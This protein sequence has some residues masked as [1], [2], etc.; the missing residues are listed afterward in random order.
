MTSTTLSQT[1]LNFARFSIVSIDINKLPLKDILTIFI[2]PTDLDQAIQN[3]DPLLKGK[4]KLNPDQRNT[5]CNTS[6]NPPDYS[7]F[8]I[9]LLYRLIRNLCPSLEPTNKWGNKPA[10]NDLDVGDDIERIRYLRNSIVA[11]SAS[12]EISDDKFKD[13]WS[14]VKCIIQR[15]QQYTTSKGCTNDYNKMLID[16]ERK[17]FTFDEYTIQKARSRAICVF[18]ESEIFCGKTACFEAEIT[19]EDDVFL[20]VSWDRVDGMHRKQLDVRDEKYR[21]SDNRQLR[22]HNVCKDDEAGYQAVLSR[23]YDVK[24]LSNTVY[25]RPK[26]DLP[27]LE[28]LNATSKEGTIYIHYVFKVSE[29]SPI[30]DIRWTKNNSELQVPGDKYR[31]GEKA[32]SCFTIL[33]AGEDDMGLYTC[34]VWNAVGSVSKNIKL[35]IPSADIVSTSNSKVVCGSDTTFDCTVSGY[36]SPD[37]VKWQHSPDGNLFI[38]L[39][40][41]TDKYLQSRSSHSLLVRKATLKQ[42]GYYQVVVSNSIGKCTSNKLF[43]QLTGSK[44]NVS[45]VTCSLHGNSVKLKCDVFLYDESPPLNYVYWTK[46]VKH[47]VIAAND[48]KYSGADINDPSLTIYNVNNDDAGEYQLIAVNPVGETWST[49]I[50]LGVPEVL[51]KECVKK[52]DGSLWFTMTIKSVPV[53]HSVKWNIKENNTDTFE[54]I[55]VSAAEYIGTSTTFP[56]PVLVIKHLEKLDNCI[57]EIEVKNR[58]G[59]VKRLI[60]GNIFQEELKREKKT[61]GTFYAEGGSSI[62]FSIWLSELA[63]KFPKEKTDTLKLLIQSSCK[64]EDVTE[65]EK[66]KTAQDCFKILLKEKIICP[67]DVIAMQFFLI[68]TNCEELEK[69][70]IDYAKQQK[71]MHFYEKPPENRCRNVRFH[72]A[73]YLQQFS[74]EDETK[75]RETVSRIVGCSIEDVQVNGY[76]YSSSF[77]LVLSIK[78]IYIERLFNMKQHDKEQLSKLSIDYFKDD[79]KTVQLEQT[80]DKDKDRNMIDPSKSITESSKEYCIGDNGQDKLKQAGE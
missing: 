73:R 21:G 68:R 65:L 59:E 78:E 76:L 48:E 23:N 4:Y 45:E 36:P 25:L 67:S 20:P 61:L 55:N 42:Q 3:C 74:T 54:P 56:H 19:L 24:I 13:L 17:T 14:D 47:I 53:P 12:A 50:L 49:V 7:T 43:L 39:D 77:F 60:S 58:I 15:C 29:N 1:Q 27:C 70:C 5:C 46:G 10:S 18:G 30:K 71:A 9:T 16:L 66:A 41:D 64:I 51:L 37:V 8:D 72:V 28:D 40:T 6:P 75:I 32:D 69:E 26:G 31:G 33:M 11:H 52:E 44:P 63:E 22:I 38:D 79:F 35:G 2:Q 62:P 34:T 57:F 80:A